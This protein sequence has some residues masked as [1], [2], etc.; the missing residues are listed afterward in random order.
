MIM[1]GELTYQTARNLQQKYSKGGFDILYGHG[2]KG[3]D[4]QMNLGKI[5]SWFGE[6]YNRDAILADMDI[7]LV[8]QETDR[9]F[10]LI[11]IEETSIKP[12]VILGDILSILLGNGINF[13][14]NRDLQIGAFTDLIVMVQDN[15]HSHSVR[16]DFL[17]R[18]CNFIKERLVTSNSSIGKII[19]DTFTDNK[20]LEDKLIE[21][22]E[23]TIL[24]E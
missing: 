15:N 11:E 1:K 16:V 7:A 10:A 20:Q 6:E 9:V 19:I 3:M 18:Q 17:S 13:Q 24:V 5:R 4:S 8:K 14:G 21:H 22:L 23:K 12:K 2:E